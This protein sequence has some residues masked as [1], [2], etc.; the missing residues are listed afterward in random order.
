VQILAISPEPPELS[1]KLVDSVKEKHNVDLKFP[2]LEDSGH[3]VIDRYGLLNPASNR[4][5]P[6][7]AVYVIDKSGVIRWKFV[8]TNYKTRATNEQILEALKPLS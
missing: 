8:E 2:L 7:P 3:K 1:R 6:H 4:G 5:I